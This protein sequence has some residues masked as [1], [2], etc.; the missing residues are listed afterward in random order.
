MRFPPIASTL[1]SRA[2]DSFVEA[3]ISTLINLPFSVAE[4]VASKAIADGIYAQSKMPGA[5]KRNVDGTKSTVDPSATD[6]QKIAARLEGAEIKTELLVNIILSINEG[7]DANAVGKDPAASTDINKRLTALEKRMDAVEAQ[8]E[9]I[10]KR[11]GLI[12]S[13]YQKPESLEGATDKSRIT[14][15]EQRYKHM[16]LMTK[17][18]ISAKQNQ[19]DLED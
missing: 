13:P 12:Y 5:E 3:G 1:A 6:Q 19:I 15:I 17:N 7:G 14:S 11:Y 9:D 2:R 4:H 16:N 18:L 8:M 10:G